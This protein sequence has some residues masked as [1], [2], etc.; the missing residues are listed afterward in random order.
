MKRIIIASL[1]VALSAL[2]L[3]A[4]SYMGLPDGINVNELS[5]IKWGDRVDVKMQLGLQDGTRIGT[6][7]AVHIIPVIQKGE[8]IVF[9]PEVVMYGRNRQI[10]NER[11]EVLPAD[12]AYLLERPKAGDPWGVINYKESVPFQEWM[13]EG[14][15]S[16]LTK[17]TGCR[18]CLKD[19]LPRTLRP[20]LYTPQTTLAYLVPAVEPVKA[21]A[22]RYVATVNFRVDKHN[23]DP[24][25][26]NNKAIL[27]GINKVMTE[28]A[29]DENIEVTKMQIFGFAS[30]EAPVAY[31]KALSE[32]RTNELKKYLAQRYPKFADV[33]SSEGKGEDWD[34]TRELVEGSSLTNKAKVL[35]IIKL[36]SNPDARDQKIKDLDG[37]KT[38]YDMLNNLY[39]KVRRTEYE[40]AYTVRGFDV[41]EAKEIIKTKPNQLSLNEMYLVAQTY[42][43]G[44]EDF[45]RVMD[46]AYKF[47]PDQPAAI[48]NS[49]AAD[50]EA[51][52]YQKA[53]DKLA[54]ISDKPE[55]LNNIGVAYTKMEQWDKALTY[56]KQAADLGNAQASAALAELRKMGL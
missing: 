7:D 9:L 36:I 17:V 26:M 53:I 46:T 20:L 50:I 1:I 55:A 28:V 5:S 31:N 37:G 43:P 21:R 16:L 6:N 41:E 24:N 19:E 25:Y 40:V 27:D 3:L 56:F 4:Q 34:K 12:D 35:E 51:G 29:K 52:Q 18:D 11:N 15:L 30:P 49:A 8:N 33:M 13:R 23:L 2:P 42:E 22:D 10:M 48:L 38:Y 44:S 54:K 32:R 14:T 45:K 47:F 39:P